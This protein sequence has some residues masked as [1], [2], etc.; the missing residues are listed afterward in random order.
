MAQEITSNMVPAVLHAGRPMQLLPVLTGY[1]GYPANRVSGGHVH[2]VYHIVPVFTGEAWLE[3]D[4]DRLRLRPGTVVVINPDEKHVFLTSASA[5]TLFAFNFYL[6]PF[7]HT[8]SGPGT[9]DLQQAEHL[10]LRTPF[11][12]LFG[13]LPWERSA[14][15]MD[16][17]GE[18]WARM[19]D[20]VR[21]FH[22]DIRPCMEQGHPPAQARLQD[23]YLTRCVTFLYEIVSILG[24]PGQL[25][26]GDR[27]DHDPII[28]ETDK[29]LREQLDR[30]LDLRT[31]AADVGRSH[32]YLSE[33]FHARTG[34]TLTEYHASLRIARA[35]ELLRDH[36]T[37]ISRIALEL[38]Y[39]SPQHFCAAFR[40]VRHVSPRQYR[41]QVIRD[42]L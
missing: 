26:A 8:A 18:R 39:S 32:A 10:A 19:V 7:S 4:H 34:M 21:R 41:S 28:R 35:C 25:V 36:G 16:P 33:L 14:I 17:H 15:V 38:G 5:M 9:V 13:G 20:E 24:S 22:D 12:Q 23:W 2:A 31:I 6:I 11:E 3:R 27:F 30:K 40:K 1:S 37:P 42:G 29:L